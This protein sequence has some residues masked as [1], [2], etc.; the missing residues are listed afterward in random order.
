[1]SFLLLEVNESMML[2]I[3]DE[4]AVMEGELCVGA[5]KY[6][7]EEVL[8]IKTGMDDPMTE[9]K[10]GFK[11]GTEIEIRVW[12]KANGEEYELRSTEVERSVTQFKPLG[13]E[14]VSLRD[15][16]LKE[17]AKGLSVNIYPNPSKGEFEISLYCSTRDKVEIQVYDQ[18]GRPVA[19]MHDREFEQGHHSIGWPSNFYTSVDMKSG[20]YIIMIRD[21]NTTIVDRILIQH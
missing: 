1:M 3:G 6:T 5:V 15:G 13:V 12:K 21:S 16:I 9:W 7:G 19:V 11:E 4:I 18:V 8:G 20:V 2:D 17:L 14:V 10:D